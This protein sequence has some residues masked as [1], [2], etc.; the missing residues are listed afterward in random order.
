ME[1]SKSSRHSKITGDFAEHLVLYWLSKHGFECAKVDHTGIDIIAKNPH[2]GELLGISVKSR[3]R[4]KGK[5]TD[6]VTIRNDHFAKVNE[7]CETFG[8]IPYFAIVVDA[9]TKILAIL[10]SM[11]ELEKISPQRKTTASWKMRPK[12]IEAYR[13]NPNVVIFELEHDIFR[14]FDEL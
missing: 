8:C 2:S 14:W 9:H 10:L 12:N 13:Q 7:A 1:L 3:S 5:E 6:H 4:N 11:E